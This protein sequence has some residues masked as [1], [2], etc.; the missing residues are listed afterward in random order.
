MG[1]GYTTMLHQARQRIGIRS[2]HYTVSRNASI[3]LSAAYG[4]SDNIQHVVT[5]LSGTS[6]S[7]T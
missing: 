7:A 4:L 5:H 6:P 2:D 3:R 1:F